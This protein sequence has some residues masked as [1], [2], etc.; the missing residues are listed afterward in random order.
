MKRSEMGE[1]LMIKPPSGREN[2]H[3]RLEPVK[4]ETPE[5]DNPSVSRQE[6]S[7]Y[8]SMMVTYGITLAQAK[9]KRQAAKGNRA[10]LKQISDDISMESAGHSI[11]RVSRNRKIPPISSGYKYK[12]VTI[13]APHPVVE[14]YKPDYT[15]SARRY[16]DTVTGE[17]IPRRER[18]RRIA[19]SVARGEPDGK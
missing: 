15:T 12:A 17:V 9:R 19:I 10:A 7:Y 6:A 14:R 5:L 13:H 18:D 8:R 16:T 2:F 3:V 4:E 1:A 11:K